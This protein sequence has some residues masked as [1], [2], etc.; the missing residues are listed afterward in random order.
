MTSKLKWAL[1]IAAVV[2]VVLVI[3]QALNDR[4]TNIV[5]SLAAPFR[6]APTPPTAA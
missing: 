6:P 2:I 1:G 4:G 5:T 3:V